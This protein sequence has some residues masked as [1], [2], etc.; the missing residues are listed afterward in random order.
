MAEEIVD[1][2]RDHEPAVAIVGHPHDLA[3]I[4]LFTLQD[5]V[6]QDRFPDMPACAEQLACWDESLGDFGDDSRRTENRELRAERG[7]QV[8]AM[9]L[10]R[11]REAI[12]PGVPAPAVAKKGQPSP[13]RVEPATSCGTELNGSVSSS[14]QTRSTHPWRPLWSVTRVHSN[15]IHRSLNLLQTTRECSSGV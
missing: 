4:V 11:L 1:R 2:D 14:P 15:R 6:C 12:A 13:T 10:V 8:T 3:R 9:T 5:V 7:E